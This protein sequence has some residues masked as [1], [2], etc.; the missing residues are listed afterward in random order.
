MSEEQVSANA[1]Q[2]NANASVENQEEKP[3]VQETSEG[4]DRIL[5]ESKAWKKRAQEAEQRLK[6]ME[7]KTLKEQ[8]NYKSLYEKKDQEVKLLAQKLMSDKKKLALQAGAQKFKVRDIQDAL[9]L[10]N[11]DLLQYDQE[12]DAFVGVDEFFE[13]LKVRKPYFFESEK[14]AVAT[15]ARPG[16]QI[17]EVPFD[18]LSLDE[19]EKAIKQKLA[20][21]FK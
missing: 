6:D 10:G 5:K 17:K 11:K 12:A 3:V 15:P 1:E 9:A 19:R 14:T 7:E 4:G 8:N 21:K 20:E 2:A 16:G 13:D 18:Q